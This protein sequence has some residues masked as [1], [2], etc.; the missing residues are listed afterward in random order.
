MHFSKATLVKVMSIS[1][2]ILVLVFVSLLSPDSLFAWPEIRHKA[3]NNLV[4]LMGVTQSASALVTYRL[5]RLV[6]Y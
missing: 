6:R 5:Y 3:E 1:K 2:H 4:S